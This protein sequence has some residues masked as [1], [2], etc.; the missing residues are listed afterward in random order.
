MGVPDEIV[1]HGD[2][3]L[4]LAKYGLNPEGIASR[5]REA[6]ADFPAGNLNK[7]KLKAVR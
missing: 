7:P 5:I 2:P 6:M 3:K 4:L 1:T